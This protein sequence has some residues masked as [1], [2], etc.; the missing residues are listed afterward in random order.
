[1]NA[2]TNLRQAV[3]DTSK[4]LRAAAA[5]LAIARAQYE[6]AADAYQLAVNDLVTWSNN[7]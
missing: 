6:A 7:Q 3:V 5:N 2:E 1:M 4:A